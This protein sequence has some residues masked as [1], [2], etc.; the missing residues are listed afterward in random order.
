MEC[1]VFS[2]DYETWKD[3]LCSIRQAVFTK[4]Q[5]IDARLD[6]DGKDTDAWHAL[7]TIDDHYIGT[8]RLQADGKIGRVA[9]LAEFRNQGVGSAIM[10]ELERLAT[11]QGLQGIY[12]HA[13]ESSIEFYLKLGYAKEGETFFEAGIPHV[14]M[15]KKLKIHHGP[16]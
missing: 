9:V 2:A 16:R 3:Q 13:Q 6:L 14:T 15:R 5:E 1:K 4:E 10:R 11:I 7:A 12:L 8:G